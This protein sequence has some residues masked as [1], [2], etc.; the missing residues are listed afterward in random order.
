MTATCTCSAARSFPT[1]HRLQ[2]LL[3]LSSLTPH[4]SPLFL[5]PVCQNY[6]DPNIYFST[7]MGTTWTVMADVSFL[8]QSDGAYFSYATTSCAAVRLTQNG[9]NGIF[10]KAITIYGGSVWLS[11][12]QIVEAVQGTTSLVATV[13]VPQVTWTA[14]ETFIVPRR[15]YPSC[16]YN[17]HTAAN[18]LPIMFILGGELNYTNQVLENDIWSVEAPTPH[19]QSDT[20]PAQL[21]SCLLC[22]VA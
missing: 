12:N 4:L 19:A 22:C 6:V 16:T 9:I 18:Q 21:Y 3:P 7:D 13:N 8:G 10:Y 15:T 11:D 2:Q 20:P 17:V 1:S 5:C 14:V